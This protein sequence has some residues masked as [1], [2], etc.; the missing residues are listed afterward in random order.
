MFY[1]NKNFEYLNDVR[2]LLSSFIDRRQVIEYYQALPLCCFCIITMVT[3]QVRQSRKWQSRT[4][5]LQNGAPLTIWLKIGPKSTQHGVVYT[6]SV[7]ESEQTSYILLQFLR[8]SFRKI[9]I[10]NLHIL[11]FHCLIYMTFYSVKLT[12]TSL[13]RVVVQQALK[14]E[15]RLVAYR[16]S[17]RE[18]QTSE[19][20]YSVLFLV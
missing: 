18:I 8:S 15:K 12:E 9:Q 14:N 11:H 7:R 10:S 1:L 6:K 17:I 16:Y 3:K 19:F 5:R 20:A 13:H 2:L 4:K